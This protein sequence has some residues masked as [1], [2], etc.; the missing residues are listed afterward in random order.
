MSALDPSDYASGEDRYVNFGEDFLG[1]Q[2]ADTQK[3]LM[4]SITQNQRI[5]IIS[6]NGV[7]KSYGV[8][9]LILAFLYT[10]PDSVIL[11]TSG[12][13]GQFIDTMWGPLDSM[14]KKVK[15]EHGL[16]GKI[17]RGNKPSIEVNP[18]WFFRVTSPRDPGELEGRHAESVLV[19]IE[20]ADKEYI[21]AEHFDSAGSS[22]TDMNDKMIAIANPPDDEA[23]VV[24]EKAQEDRWTVIDFSSFESHNVQVDAGKRDGDHIEGLVDLIT[25]ADD[26]EAWNDRDWP[27]TPDDWKGV[28][29]YKELVQ[30]GEMSRE[31]LIEQLRP[32]FDKARTM[33]RESDDLDKRW[34]KR[35]LGEIPPAAATVH[36]PFTI[37]DVKTA[38]DRNPEITTMSPDGVGIDVARKGGDFNVIAAV[39]GDMIKIHRRWSDQDHNV[40]ER[41]IRDT[42]DQW[43]DVPV[44]IDASPEGSGLAD[45]VANFAPE[46]VRFR[47]G[48]TAAFDTTYFDKW[49]EG[50]HKL[51]H[52]LEDGGCF[53]NR[54]LREEMLSAA[55]HVETEEKYYKRRNDDVYKASSKEDIKDALG[56]SPDML[57]A[58]YMAVWAASDA[59]N[60]E[61]REQKLVW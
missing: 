57:D 49:T 1:V 14:C 59:P 50:L 28:N 43:P 26:W 23:N 60:A 40:G 30:M 6:G 39:H 7:G 34:Y 2:L 44:A 61:Y 8:A 37:D 13:Y 31:R 55:R 33:H 27:E 38:F 19:V 15:E 41:N 4:R 22:I 9:I 32:G 36:R 35:R 56:R 16:P 11:G 20:E 12:S 21:T 46:M 5:L 17:Y 47:A 53:D 3:Q 45:R 58:A 54:R 42:L 48:E 52:F 25:I 24:Y 29:H 18:E 51:G 10:N